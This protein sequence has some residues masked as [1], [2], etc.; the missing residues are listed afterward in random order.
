MM[1]KELKRKVEQDK[2]EM[3]QFALKLNNGK[4]Q[5]KELFEIEPDQ[6]NVLVCAEC[7][8]D[9]F[10]VWVEEKKKRVASNTY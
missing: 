4:P 7:G 8:I 1:Y 5:K 2:I 3:K 9:T 6:T 10:Y